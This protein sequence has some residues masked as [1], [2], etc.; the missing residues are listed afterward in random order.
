MDIGYLSCIGLRPLSLEPGV[1]NFTV[2]ASANLSDVQTSGCDAHV[3]ATTFSGMQPEHQAAEK[4]LVLAVLEKHSAWHRTIGGLVPQHNIRLTCTLNRERGLVAAH[5]TL[6][7]DFKLVKLGRDYGFPRGF[8]VVVDA[9][10]QALVGQG[11]FFP[12]FANDDR[13]SGF[14]MKDFG[15]VTKISC[16]LK[17]S[18]STGIITV[19]RDEN[20]AAIGWTASS[21]NSCNHDASTNHV[22]SYPI[23][24]MAIFSKYVAQGFLAW[25]DK[26][27]VYSIGLEVF[28]SND[29]SHGY[30]YAASGCIVTAICA[31]SYCDG[32]PLYL[33]P[34][35]MYLACHEVGLPTDRPICVQGKSCIKA[36]VEALSDVRDLL[37]LGILRRVLHEHCGVVLE[38][39]HDRLIDSDIVEGFVIRRWKDEVEVES[40]KFKIWLYQ[41]VTQVL[42]PSFSDVRFADFSG[43]MRSFK[44][45]EGRLRP[46]F[47][48]MVKHEL[49]KWCVLPNAATRELCQWVVYTA[50]EAC[51]PDGHAQ[52]L[53][54]ESQ[55]CAFPADACVPDGCVARDPV[56]AYWITLGDYAVK[57]L[58]AVME[59]AGFDVQEAAATIR[60]E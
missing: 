25:C 21:K 13:N 57:K 9:D 29:Q 31:G 18:G 52:L 33:S 11:V 4:E 20:G 49:Q 55:G 60:S 2:D 40:V 28:F 41:M 44:S 54:S 5:L 8:C 3:L 12:K 22:L 48:S 27:Q 16:F 15:G 45:S 36:F 26:R 43:Q 53:W 38:T 30:G 6:H 17:Y 46:Q 37:T 47:S 59:A 19:L 39:M 50:G 24:I 42:R 10:R 51:L 58:I 34:E 32:R 1:C 14:S 7:N 23:E 56:R 35:E